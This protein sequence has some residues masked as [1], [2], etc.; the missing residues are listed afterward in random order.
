MN[1]Q[2]KLSC[3]S[4][5]LDCVK[6]YLFNQIKRVVCDR[7]IDVFQMQNE[8]KYTSGTDSEFVT[9][10]NTS[11]YARCFSRIA[12]R[13]TLQDRWASIS[14]V[15]TTLRCD[16]K[17][18]RNMYQKFMDYNMIERDKNSEKLL[19]KATP[20]AIDIFDAYVKML[21]CNKGE[22]LIDYLTDLLQYTKLERKGGSDYQ[23]KRE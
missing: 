6:E 18:A 17:T 20:R 14:E 7:E 11:T 23:Q 5:K 8:N 15:T 22:S 3:G 1:I 9:W 4:D 16:D 10:L 13:A 2:T 12:L 21:Y 19:F